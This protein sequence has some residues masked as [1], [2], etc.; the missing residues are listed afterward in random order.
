MK[1]QS[2]TETLGGGIIQLLFY[3]IELANCYIIYYSVILPSMQYKIVASMG[4]TKDFNSIKW[5]NEIDNSLASTGCL[6]STLGEIMFFKKIDPYFYY[7]GHCWIESRKSFYPSLVQFESFIEY[8]PNKIRFTRRNFYSAYIW[9]NPSAYQ[10]NIYSNIFSY[11][12]MIM[13]PVQLL[14]GESSVIFHK[15]KINDFSNF[16]EINPMFPGLFQFIYSLN[17]IEKGNFG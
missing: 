14:R 5:S 4:I 11:N 13:A 10:G 6:K 15:F 1:K 17:F 7:G 3:P 8:L 9:N 12:N 2:F 16:Q